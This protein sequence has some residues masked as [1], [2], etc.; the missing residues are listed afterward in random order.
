VSSEVEG[1]KRE[2]R[3]KDGEGEREREKVREGE[4]ERE[5]EN[6]REMCTGVLT[7][8]IL[9]LSKSTIIIYICT[10]ARTHSRHYNHP[11]I[12]ACCD[13]G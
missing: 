5:R 13:S 2:Q 7:T 9:Y 12:G 11:S 3:R 4:G 10:H 1:E 8:C 6:E